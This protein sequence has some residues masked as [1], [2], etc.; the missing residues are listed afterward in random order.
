M[1]VSHQIARSVAVLVLLTA[2]CSFDESGIGGRDGGTEP[3]ADANP[4]GADAR[5]GVDAAP[6]P[7]AA[8]TIVDDDNDG[9]A[10]GDDNCPQAKNTEQWDEDSDGVGDVCDNC[11]SVSN[12]AQTNVLEF[13]SSADG[14]GDACDPRPT[15]GGDTILFFDGF[16]GPID[17][18]W[19]LGDGPNNWLQSGGQLRQLGTTKEAR[20]IFWN[21]ATPTRVAVDT[22][23]TPLTLPPSNGAD[24]DLRSGGVVTTYALGD[25]IGWGYNCRTYYDP[26]IM[27]A[28]TW[29]YLISLDNDAATILDS[30]ELLAPMIEGVPFVFRLTVDGAN[31]SQSCALLSATANPTVS[32]SDSDSSYESGFVGLRTHSMSAAFDFVTVYALGN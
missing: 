29:L 22:V 26:R 32:L 13:P 10:N 18:A 20:L 2:G 19:R 6:R 15:Q 21:G 9:V 7:D 23:M 17:T 4:F 3:L 28:S 1:T 27:S 5:R 30:A 12:A 24:D 11:P 25:R 14:V 31:N 8:P 16:N